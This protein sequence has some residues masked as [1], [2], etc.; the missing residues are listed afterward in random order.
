MSS[1]TSSF[2]IEEKNKL[3]H[4]F[5]LL[6][7]LFLIHLANSGMLTGLINFIFHQ[8]IEAVNFKYLNAAIAESE[9]TLLVLSETKSLLAVI[10]SSTGGISFFIDVQVQ[11][12]Q[13]LNV[14]VELIDYAWKISLGALATIEVLKI[15]QS[16]ATLSMTPLLVILLQSI[17]LSIALKNR[18]PT[19]ALK[20]KKITDIGLFLVIFTHI[21]IP[22]SI[23]LTATLSHHYLRDHRAAIHEQYQQIHKSLPK[24]HTVSEMHSEV[25]DSIKTFK[26]V[27]SKA[28]KH[29]TNYAGVTTKHFVYSFIEFFITPITLAILLASF[30][31]AVIRRLRH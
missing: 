5:K 4:L 17:A 3:I 15:I 31:V 6:L 10:Q 29:S 1:L 20:L 14:V 16:V 27:H 30:L 22:L 18:L 23:F 11:L 24:H 2:S 7:L 28:N 13:M 9:E 8:S 25:K 19:I 26:A 12:G 21:I